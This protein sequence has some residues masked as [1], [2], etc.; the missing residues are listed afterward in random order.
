MKFHFD[1]QT[2]KLYHAR[3]MS[4]QATIDSVEFARSGRR[5]Q[6]DVALA[7]MAR[8][9]ESLGSGG[10]VLHYVLSGTLSEK[11]HPQLV[12]EV[13]GVLNLVCQR[14]MEL[15]T[16]PLSTRSV[17]E[18]VGEGG[19]LPPLEDE[20]DTVDSIPADVAMDV[21][22]L[23]EDEVLLSLPVAPMH[24]AG[25]CGIASPYK[26]SRANPFEVLSTLRQAGRP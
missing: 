23:V 17:L 26:A 3:L 15:L 22:A 2:G 4:E 16:F 13:D 25:G 1:T 6:G 18:L 19:A 12:C 7:D 5:L 11:G 10:E 14:C 9:R 21:L 20:D 8:L 24:D